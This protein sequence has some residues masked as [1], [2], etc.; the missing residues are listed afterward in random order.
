MPIA[1]DFYNFKKRKNSTKTPSGSPTTYNCVLKDGCS[2]IAP[3]IGLDIGLTANPHQYNYAT[4]AAFGR[5]YYVS[6][7]VWEN[8]LWWANLAVDVLGTYKISIYN[9]NCYVLRAAGRYNGDISDGFYPTKFNTNAFSYY[10]S[11]NHI[12][13]VSPF[14]AQTF[15]DGFYVIGIINNDNLSIGAV[16]Y[17]AMTPSNFAI[18]KARL[19]STTDWT[20]IDV[21]NPD[22]G[23]A[24][25]KSLF[26]P[27]QYI[28]SI[29]WFPFS[30]PSNIGLSTTVL[31]F[32]WWEILNIQAYRVSEYIYNANPNSRNL[33]V[34]DHPQADARGKFLRAA[35]FSKYRLFFPPFGE[36]ELDANIIANGKWAI[37]FDADEKFCPLEY[38]LYVDLISGTGALSI[39]MDVQ[40]NDSYYRATLLYTQTQVS[41]P[42]QLAQVTNDAWG[43]LKNTVATSATVIGSL[44]SLQIGNAISSAANGILN[45][46]ESSVPHVMTTGSNGTIS[47]YVT[48]DIKTESIHQIAVD[49]SISEYG[50]PL[51]EAVQLGTLSEQN[52]QSSGYVKTLQADVQI[53][54]YESEIEQI[55]QALDG[56]VYLE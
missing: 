3:V 8:R 4:I 12:S 47:P 53:D 25:Y 44:A 7:W 42:I 20:G 22:F 55:N 26:N 24:L 54:G 33:Y 16:S 21:S 2:M 6:D 34:I 45:N 9:S 15:S 10:A 23:D 18:L 41:V 56:G 13:P 40:G 35:P 43:A 36:F 17:Y 5:N 32:G 31:P 30:M 29:N 11:R 37:Y 39:F 27:Y 28:A 51:C 38:D 14:W 52:T 48:Q 46:I 50:R 19:M 1:V 49:D